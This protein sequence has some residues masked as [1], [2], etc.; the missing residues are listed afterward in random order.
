MPAGPSGP[1][2][3]K[4]PELAP[5]VFAASPDALASALR[6]K[7]KPLVVNHWATWC[8]PCVDELPYLSEIAK[9]YD[10]RV[11]FI[12]VA[13]D[14]LSP[15][16]P[17]GPIR[18]A[19]DE[20]RHRTGAK[21]PTIVAPPDLEGMAKRLPLLSEVVPQTYVFAPSGERIW[22]Y[23]GELSSD[24]DRKAFEESIEKALRN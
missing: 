9:R 11:D 14:K 20:V 4:Y 16:R 23:Q 13:W 24:D 10:G 6:P 1:A 22:E 7:G 12:G 18:A 5:V 19:V 15:D 17:D 8:V 3:P 21:F 2:A